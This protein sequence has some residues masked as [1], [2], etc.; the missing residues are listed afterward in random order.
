MIRVPSV[1]TAT[2]KD[3][4]PPPHLDMAAPLRV[5]LQP[6]NDK[7]S[8]HNHYEGLYSP[9]PQTHFCKFGPLKLMCRHVVPSRV[10]PLAW[11]GVAPQSNR[12]V[13]KF[14]FL[15]LNIYLKINFCSPNFILF[16][17]FTTPN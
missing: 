8:R 4:T 13:L 12:V 10:D 3:D 11:G 6:H 16:F 1:V 14:L 5:V 2:M 17:N 15:F 9:P 7:G